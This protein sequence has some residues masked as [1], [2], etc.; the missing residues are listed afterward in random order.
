MANVFEDDSVEKK[1]N[2]LK[3]LFSRRNILFVVLF[4]MFLNLFYLNFLMFQGKFNLS[5]TNKNS[6]EKVECSNSCTTEINNLKTRID[7]IS[8]SSSLLLSPTP[9]SIPQN[10]NISVPKNT[11][12]K[13]YYV[14]FGSGSGSSSDWQDVAGLQ[15]YVDSTSYQSIKKVIFEASLHIPTG[16]ESA[17]V[18]L[19][20]ATDGRVIS[21]SELIFNGNTNSVFLASSPITLDYGNKLY[22]VQI[23]TQLQYPAVLD[24]SRLH[25]TTN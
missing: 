1:K 5:A 25:I 16:N 8:S 6:S 20:N 2:P 23:K 18:R 13:E 4:L 7:E 22:K 3:T 10:P 9:T 19:Y 11:V 21:G 14:P 12:A 17:S 24:Q 15:A